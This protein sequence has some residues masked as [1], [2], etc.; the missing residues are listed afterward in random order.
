MENLKV[1]KSTIFKDFRGSYWT[2]W[3]KGKIKLNF[4]H[5]KFSISKKNTL[6]GLHGDKKTWKL[7]SCVFGKVFL[8]IVNYDK[9]SKNY[10]KVKK[11]ILEDK[12][13]K[14]ILI[15]PLYL[16]GFLCLSKKCV[17][18][19]KLSY[20]GKYSDVKDQISIKWNDKRLKI[21]WPIQKNL[22]LSKR[23]K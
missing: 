14:Q 4:N 21:K 18:H 12:I 6:R 13:N 17:F 19:Y 16:N 8:V 10:L 3:K 7:V 23:D 1:F 9:K 2:T 20:K 22:M 11:V 15:P 5:D